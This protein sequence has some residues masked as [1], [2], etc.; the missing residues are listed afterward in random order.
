MRTFL[1]AVA[2]S[3]ASAARAS[4]G[5]LD[6]DLGGEAT[7]TAWPDDYGGGTSL[8]IAYFFLPWLG[9]SFI[10]K[11]QYAEVDDRLLEYFSFNA[12]FRGR[13][14]RVRITGTLGGVHQHEEPRAVWMDQPF[15]SIVGVAD[16]I[17]HRF[18]VRTGVQLA[19]PLGHYSRGDY[20]AALDLD[21]TLFTDTDKGPRW[22]TSVGVDVGFTFGFGAQ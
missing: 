7:T 6:I 9:A 11:E 17:R 10:G 13:L 20:Y 5:V 22:M 3:A 1:L 14:G 8:G 12:A 15:D 18:A 16:G 19:V 2:I 21:G 4:A